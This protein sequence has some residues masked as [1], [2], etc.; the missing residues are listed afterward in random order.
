MNHK[1]NIGDLVF[2]SA[3]DRVETRIACP[4]CGGTRHVKVVL[5]DNTEIIIECG[6]CDPGGYEPST[7]TIKQWKFACIAIPRTVTG[8]CMKSDN[9]SYELDNFGGSYFTATEGQIFATKE[10]AMADAEIKRAGQELEENKLF[11]A[12]TKSEH[13]WKWNM[14]YHRKCIKDAERELEYH[15]SKVQVCA[16]KVKDAA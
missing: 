16:A 6:G 3:Y 9:V 15:R 8:V 12:K 14:A 5:H 1:F 11:L 13:T 2:K 10:E 4:D 7:G